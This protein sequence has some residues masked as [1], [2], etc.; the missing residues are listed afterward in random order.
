[1][2][3]CLDSWAVLAWLD[4]EEPARRRVEALLDE[5][6]VMSWVNA[7]EV[8]SRVERDHGRPAAE[9]VLSD[10]RKIVEVE[11]PGVIRMIETARLKAA[12]PIALTDCFA[13]ATAAAHAIPLATGDPEI[14]TRADLPC[15]TE[16]LRATG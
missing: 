8:Y 12:L 6:P 7:V 16:D 4:G 3:A 5:R 2:T 9:E 10:L 13:L 14:L 15:A 11:L 1:M